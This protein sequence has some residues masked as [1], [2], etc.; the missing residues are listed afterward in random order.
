MHTCVHVCACIVSVIVHVHAQLYTHGRFL[1]LTKY[2]RSSSSSLIA[3]TG[4]TYQL[5]VVRFLCRRPL[6]EGY[7]HNKLFL[8][9]AVEVFL[10]QCR[11]VLYSSC[12]LQSTY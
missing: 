11:S 7:L 1:N 5:V 10:C 3:E 9:I 4:M 12:L 8:D 6:R 2:A